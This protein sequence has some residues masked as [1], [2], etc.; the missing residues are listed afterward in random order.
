MT[1]P[2]GASSCVLHGTCALGSGGGMGA[3]VLVGAVPR[4]VPLSRLG[5]PVVQAHRPV[6]DEAKAVAVRA[7]HQLAA[8]AAKLR[9]HV[10]L[11]QAPLLLPL[12]VESAARG[13][14][15][16]PGGADDD[17]PVPA[18][19]LGGGHRN[20]G[21]GD[22]EQGDG[23]GGGGGGEGQVAGSH[24]RALWSFTFSSLWGLA[25]G[26]FTSCFLLRLIYICKSNKHQMVHSQ[27]G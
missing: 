10:V 11:H 19:E 26:A 15:P 23:G 8:A 12:V 21:C 14:D 7:P 20:G 24:R 3:S 5:A 2:A 16:C 1:G 25:P 9:R 6:I 4:G 13:D 17:H 18:A 27:I 22:D